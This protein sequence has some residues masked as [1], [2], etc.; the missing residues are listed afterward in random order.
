MLV[1][2][3]RSDRI[4]SMNENKQASKQASNKT[5]NSNSNICI[6]YHKQWTNR[7]LA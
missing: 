3:V 5:N 7:M 6:A 4:V 1:K 2:L